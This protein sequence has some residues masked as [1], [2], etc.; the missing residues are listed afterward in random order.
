MHKVFNNPVNKHL[1][2]VQHEQKSLNDTDSPQK[3]KN[4]QNSK[5]FW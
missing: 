4:H 2:V 1:S 3:N 5:K